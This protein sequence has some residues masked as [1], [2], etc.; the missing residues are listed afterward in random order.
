MVFAS[1]FVTP[2]PRRSAVMMRNTLRLAGDMKWGLLGLL[3]GL[4]I[5]IVI[6]LWLFM[7]H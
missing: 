4:P 3:L 5:P 6:L 2:E 1:T 7:G